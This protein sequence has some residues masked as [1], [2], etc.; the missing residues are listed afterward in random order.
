MIYI[1]V[2]GSHASGL[3]GG[4]HE[5]I[6]GVPDLGAAVAH[7]QP[8][9]YHSVSEGRLDAGAARA[10]Y[11]RPSALQSVRLGHVGATSG[12]VRLQQWSDAAGRGLGVAPLR[13]AGSRWTVHRTRDI[14]PAL[15]WGRY[16]EKTLAGTRVTGPVI[17]SVDARSASINHAVLT[18][19]FRHVLMVRHGIDVPLYGTPDPASLLGASEVAHAGIVVAASRAESLRFYPLLGFR[20][21]SRRRVAYDPQSVATQMFPLQPGEALIEHD[22]DDPRSRPGPGQL[23]GRLRAF[24]LEPGHA[25][26]FQTVPGDAGYNLY[27]LRHGAFGAAGAAGDWLLGLGAVSLGAG[28]DEFGEPACRFRAPDGYEWLG[29][30]AA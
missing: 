7:W 4:I 23:P 25:T 24:V 2:M 5:V 21:M 26:D 16:L 12:L 3:Q 15:A 14:T 8:F 10:L 22:F 20:A 11:G 9:G 18:P 19:H 1:T 6:V 17:H 29:L 30:P 13:V 27:S 28:R